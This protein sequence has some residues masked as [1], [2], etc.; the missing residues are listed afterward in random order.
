MS[1]YNSEKTERDGVVFDSKREAERYD[2]L[3]L[4]QRAGEISELQRQ[5]PF[6]LQ[7][8]FRKNGYKFSPLKY[9]ADFVYKDKN[10]KTVVEDVKGFATDVYRIKRKIFEHEFPDLTIM[11]V[12]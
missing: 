7:E 10:G 2:E 3:K 9:V 4:L 5:V 1:K 11:E 12:R 8:G 6:I